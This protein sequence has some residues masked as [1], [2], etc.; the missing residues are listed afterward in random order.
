MIFYI[1]IIP[2]GVALLLYFLNKT[3]FDRLMIRENLKYTGKVNNYVDVFRVLKTIN[4]SDTL[5]RFEKKFLIKVIVLK[6][7][8]WL[9]IVTWLLL[10]IYFSESILN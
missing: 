5:N 6:G 7:V 3:K 4:S 1:T 8:A 9:S 2:G 10:F